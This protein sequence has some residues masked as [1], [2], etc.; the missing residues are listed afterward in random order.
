MYP[1]KHTLPSK[2]KSVK[3]TEHISP[4]GSIL[5]P[6]SESTPAHEASC[7]VSDRTYCSIQWMLPCS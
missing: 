3:I 6:Q 5:W 7:F 1:D 2:E 4:V